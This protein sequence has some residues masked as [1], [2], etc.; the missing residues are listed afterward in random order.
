MGS[1]TES[2]IR[3]PAKHPD[4]TMLAHSAGISHAFSLAVFGSV[5]NAVARHSHHVAAYIIA[6]FPED[7]AERF[8]AERRGSSPSEWRREQPE[9]PDTVRLA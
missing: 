8:E 3:K 7:R 5:H 6:A 2:Q 1:A 9:R 4:G